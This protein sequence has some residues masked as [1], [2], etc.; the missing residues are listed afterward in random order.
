[1]IVRPALAIMRNLH[2]LVMLL[3]LVLTAG[4]SSL[5]SLPRTEDPRITMRNPIVLTR[6]PGASPER[7]EALVSEKIE[8]KLKEISGIR[9]V[10]STSRAGISVVSI[11]LEDHVYDS[12]EVFAEIR[13]QIGAAVP[14]LPAEA[15]PPIFDDKRGATAFSMIAALTTTREKQLGI[16][17][18]LAEDLADRLRAVSGT[19]LVRLYGEP[20]EEL[21]A[22]VDDAE[23]AALGLTTADLAAALLAADAESPSGLLRG[24]DS[25]LVLEVRGEL[26]SLE[27]VRDVPLR[28]AADGALVRVGDV[29]QVTRRWREPAEEIGLVD[30]I[31]AVY[32]AARMEPGERADVW[33]ARARR[34]VRGFEAE[35]GGPVDLRVVFD[36]SRYTIERLGSLDSNLMLGGGV[37]VAVVLFTMGLRAGLVVGAAL[38]LTAALAL[39]GLLASGG[40]L[41]QMS[42]FGMTIAL[43]L[44]I[45]NAIVVVDEV[46]ARLREGASRELAVEQAVSHL[47]SPLLASTLTTVL[48]FAPIPLLI[49]N[50]GDFVA[51]IG[52]AV[53]LALVAS[54]ALSMTVV[55]ALA[56]R[57][58]AGPEA[59][60]E[61]TRWWHDGLELPRAATAW[62]RA[63]AAGLRRPA[64]AIGIAIALPGLGFALSPKLGSQFFPPVD[65][66]MFDVQVWLPGDASLERTRGLVE[67]VEAVMRGHEEVQRVAWL[68]GGSFPS[69]FYNL[70]MSRDDASH[71][72]RGT[73]ETRT[74]AEVKT[75]LPVLQDEI[76][77]VVPD[78]QVVVRQFG[79]GPPVEAEVELELRGPALPVLQALG[80]EVRK[81]LI[82]RP[83][84]LHTQATLERGTPKLWVDVDEDEARLAG[85]TLR[86]VAAQLEGRLEGRTGGS[87]RE[88]FEELPVRVRTRD[89]E[90]SNRDGLSD[91]QL[92]RA[93]TRD[94]LPLAA[95]GELELRPEIGAV[96]RCDG[97]RCN[98][99]RGYL[100]AG[101]LPI[102]V[103]N[104][105]MA[106]LEA[107]GFSLPPGY[108]LRVGGDS[109]EQ[110]TAVSNLLAY[111]PVL[112]VLMLATVV[113]SFRSFALA[114]LLLGV[115]GLSAGVGLLATW[116]AGFPFSFNSI[117]GTAGLIG[118][119]LND[120]IVVL[121]AIRGERR[122]RQGETDAVVEAVLGCGRHVVST[123]LTTI[124]GF[125]PLLVFVGGDFWP[126]LAIVLAGG[127]AGATVLA[128]VFVPAGYLLLTRPSFARRAREDPRARTRTRALRPLRALTRT[129]VGATGTARIARALQRS[130]GNGARVIVLDPQDVRK[131]AEQ[132]LELGGARAIEESSEKSAA[133]RSIVEHAFPGR[134]DAVR[135][136]D[137]K[138]RRQTSVLALPIEEASAKVRSGPPVDEE[139]DCAREVWAGVLPLALAAQTPVPDARPSPG[140]GLPALV[141]SCSRAGR[142]GSA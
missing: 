3:F 41:Q 118:V 69:V 50:V 133:L 81:R 71:Y 75:L 84:V 129:H 31:R 28:I 7:V 8:Q 34:V 102:E 137:R 86:D 51:P 116:A 136:P 87:V 68:V 21:T 103:T 38:P 1:M 65:R 55:P 134:F 97:V 11:T 43:G 89:A 77:R 132:L 110:A 112:G 12:E 53:I 26:D 72:A 78:A 49:G 141:S 14:L 138:E 40:S 88:G 74:A 126:P 85:L 111:A 67:R 37:V 16:L 83:E 63:L 64:L 131:A 52:V 33:A 48:A 122:A 123:T 119:A 130:P 19:E 42:I 62:R 140:V 15:S 115:A 56:G 20:E 32:V 45:D 117:L 13:D 2:L 101:S 113:L 39:F 73:V 76:D 46:S 95:L 106:S 47:F 60:A 107:S 18:R 4:A 120:S 90:R 70:V 105:A 57:F 23:L 96:T 17:S 9:S 29:A 127:V 61:G 142:R 100:R 92:L 36:Q 121:A 79:Q 125:L 6:L 10:D 22:V 94:W 114:A 30:G 44:L 99:V 35:V 58:V 54:F 91:T 139:E 109:E 66:N 27:R 93:T 24:P 108:S 82:E 98:Q 5:L 80:E 59:G 135:P 124:G 128:T 25:D 104:A